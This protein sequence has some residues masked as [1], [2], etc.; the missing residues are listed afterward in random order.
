MASACFDNLE[1][2]VF[3][4]NDSQDNRQLFKNPKK[5]KT[6]FSDS[7]QHLLFCNQFN[8]LLVN[9]DRLGLHGNIL[10]R[11]MATPIRQN[12]GLKFSRKDPALG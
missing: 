4:K 9:L 7:K 3:N 10:R 1:D 6:L 8:K 2:S 5:V 11:A 12:L